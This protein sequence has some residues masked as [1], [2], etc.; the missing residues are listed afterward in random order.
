[1]DSDITELECEAQVYIR[2]LLIAAGLYNSCTTVLKPIENWVFKEVEE[3]YRKGREGEEDATFGT[4]ENHKILFDLLN[5]TLLTII[6][7]QTRRSRFLRQSTRSNSVVHGKKL[8]DVSWQK[9]G[10]YIYP[11]AVTIHSMDT[12]V[13]HDLRRAKWF[14]RETNEVDVIGKEVERMIWVDLVE[15]AMIDI[16]R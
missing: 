14:D 8:L 10:M 3:A 9:M 12:M 15:E 16:C 1:M 2:D 7:S 13:A 4:I 11:P 6:D 5:E